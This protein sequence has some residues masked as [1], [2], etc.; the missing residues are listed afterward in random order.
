MLMRG[1]RADCILFA[2]SSASAL[3]LAIAAN[4]IA[5]QKL[6][7]SSTYC[8]AKRRRNYRPDNGIADGG[9]ASGGVI[10]LFRRSTREAT[11]LL[12]TAD[13]GISRSD[14]INQA[15]SEVAWP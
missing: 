14:D 4:L 8:G 11:W 13:N 12:T 5:P 3:K 1:V 9:A 2:S 7:L 6:R 15:V 10:G